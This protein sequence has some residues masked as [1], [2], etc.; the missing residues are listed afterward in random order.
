MLWLVPITAYH[1]RA[2][3]S[4]NS[5]QKV[6][7]FSMR[8]KLIMEKMVQKWGSAAK[9]I[10]TL[11]FLGATLTSALGNV[12]ASDS[13]ALP[14]IIL[15]VTDDQGYSDVGAFGAQNF[16]TPHLDR[17]AREGRRF[18]DFYVAASVCTASRA[19]LMT[20]SYP[21]RVSMFGALNHTS[22]EGIH[23]DELL[24]PEVVKQKGYA[25][26]CYGKWH[27][28]TVVEFFPTRNG[29]DEFLGIPYSNDNS[30]Y[31]PIVED[32]PPL[33]F[34]DNETVIA[35][36]LDQSEFTRRLTEKSVQFI[37]SNKDRPFFLYVPHIMPHVPIFASGEFLGSS[38]LGL[39][40]DVIQEIDSSVGE[41]VEAIKRNGIGKQ[42]LI[43]F[44][45]DNGPFLSYG[46]HAGHA[47]PLR[48][49][50]LTTFEGGFRSPCIMRWAEAIPA[51][52]VCSEMITSMDLLPTIADLIGVELP[53]DR[54]IDGLNI[55]PLLLGEP[56]AQSPHDAFY[57]YAG[58]ELQ[59]IRSGDYK[60]H[61]PHQY[62]TTAA[63]PGRGG[64]PSNHGRLE[65]MSITSS[66]LEG[67]A[68][69]HGYRV[70]ETPKA[71][72]NLRSDPG[73]TTNVIDQHPEVVDQMER[74]AEKMRDELGDSM[75]GRTGGRIRPRATI[76]DISDERLLIKRTPKPGMEPDLIQP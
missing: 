33:P 14:N 50:K 1:G 4:L 58:T 53:D 61:F 31:H 20:G 11:S 43:I 35:F 46:E 67:I 32:M 9:T 39:Y 72:F 30:K 16:K 60:L 57:F 63:E 45:S 21:P 6:A 3:S 22:R 62:L 70:V 2:L 42:T 36:D 28:G 37:D 55:K 48:E 56:E 23:P 8:G 18:T 51:G 7:L 38:E 75:T 17:L 74:L 40:G 49:G 10:L 65:P 25:T 5:R 13:K 66:G 47:D 19:S 68:S 41:I 71:L 52:T 54:P 26:A 29:F 69:R 59:A 15:I 73:E 44:F 12:G 76:F 64:F 27:L 24:L 34:Y